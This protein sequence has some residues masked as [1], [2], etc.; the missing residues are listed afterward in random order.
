MRFNPPSRFV[1]ETPVL[2][3]SVQDNSHGLLFPFNA[4]RQRE[5]TSAPFYRF[6]CP[7]RPEDRSGVYWRVPR[8]QLR[9]RSQVFSTSQ[10]LA[11]LNALLPFSDRWRSWGS[12]SRELFL[13]RSLQRFI[14][15]RLPSCRCSRRSRNPMVL[16][17]GF[18]WA[19]DPLPRMV[20]NRAYY[21]LQGLRPRESQPNLQVTSSMSCRIDLPLL[22]FHL[23]MVLTLIS[24]QCLRSATATLGKLLV[25]C[26]IKNLLRFAA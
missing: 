24:V 21:R 10:R 4:Y 25:R 1:P 6:G 8:R 12:P 7:N 15:A 23:L 20:R 18:L 14:T 19:H 16:G 26:Q 13:S 17:Q 2:H 11:P 5:S 22:G 3:L 9:C